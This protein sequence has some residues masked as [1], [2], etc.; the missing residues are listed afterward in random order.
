MLRTVFDHGF[1]HDH[2]AAAKE[3]TRDALIERARR[4]RTI[5]YSEL[6]THIRSIYFQ[7]H[8]PRL[9][10][11]LGEVS[12]EEEEAGRGMLTV[13]VVHK[14]GDMAP[15]SGFY[16]LATALGREIRDKDKFWIEEL[17]RV[18]AFWATSSRP[19][20]R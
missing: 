19:R 6:V 11:L 4:R 18:F 12:A 17:N 15:G 5:P 3:E 2:W 13:V 10:H 20:S 8:D 1:P 16:E 14:S 9:F 7:P